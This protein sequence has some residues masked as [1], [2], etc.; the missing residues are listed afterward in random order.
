MG[1]AFANRKHYSFVLY[2][3][4]NSY[5][6]SQLHRLTLPLSRTASSFPLI[7][8]RHVATPRKGAWCA[9]GFDITHALDGQLQ[10]VVNLYI[11][12]KKGVQ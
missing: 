4:E 9:S 8:T 1:E 11:K 12:Q 10:A 5:T 2:S 6:R 3:R 7:N